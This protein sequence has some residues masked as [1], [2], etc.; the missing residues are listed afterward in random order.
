MYSQNSFYISVSEKNL[1]KEQEFSLI[2][3]NL[4][5]TLN[6]LSF[7]NVSDIKKAVY[8]IIINA[9]TKQGSEYE[10]VYTS[11][12]SANVSIINIKNKSE[13]YVQSYSNIKAGGLNYSHAG[14]KALKKISKKIN[15][16]IEIELMSDKYKNLVTEKVKPKNSDK[17]PPKIT[18]ISPNFIN[19]IKTS[20][21]NS[22]YKFKIKVTDKNG[23]ASVMINDRTIKEYKGI[24]QT[25]IDLNGGENIVSVVATDK[26]NNTINS[27]YIIEKVSEENRS[28]TEDIKLLSSNEIIW[29]SP[30]YK[31]SEIPFSNLTVDV[32]IKAKNI[33][34]IKLLVNDNVVKDISYNVVTFR[35][36][37]CDASINKKIVLKE[38]RN[39]LKLVLQTDTKTIES[40]RIVSYSI[41]SSRYYALIIAAQDYND[42]RIKDLSNPI[43]DANKLK[44]ILVNNYTFEDTDI[45]FLKNPTKA[46][47]IGELHHL[48]KQITN[49]DNLLIFYAGHGYWDEE[50]KTGY[51]LPIDS[52]KDNP[53]N[54]MPNTDLT[55]YLNA[56]KAKHILLVADACFSGGIFKTRAAFTDVAAV[57]KLYKMPSR[58][59]ITSGTLKEVP[60]DSVF[61]KFLLK[62]LN[63]NTNKYLTAEEL[64]SSIKMAVINNS[65]NVPQYGTIQN[66]GD[67]GGDFIF[68]KK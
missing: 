29:K 35:G 49:N 28:I 47:I 10:G 15:S 51:W 30:Q 60:D 37:Q 21:K 5:K 1:D 64:F 8:K 45:K 23:I 13:V 63:E 25:Q 55:N 24:Y 52:D 12:A 59:A 53:V 9:N 66:T 38:G 26:Y 39:T 40:E 16:D 62:R 43:S 42:D 61:L 22:T 6:K 32:C 46:D 67:E 19:G 3:S 57:E 36:E 2:K 20:T 68:L 58:K 56:I 4:T 17:T 31:I 33:K 54:W 41:K 34:S 44:T 50:M 27:N 14:D 7:S 48:R 18:V 65:Q 11:F